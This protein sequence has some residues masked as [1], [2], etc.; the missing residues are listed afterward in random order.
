M[1]V[2]LFVSDLE[3]GMNL[4]ELSFDAAYDRPAASTSC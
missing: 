3:D 1:L 4:D 2:E